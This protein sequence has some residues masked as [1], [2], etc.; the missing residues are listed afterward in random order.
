MT[1]FQEGSSAGSRRSFAV[2]KG[3][4]TPCCFR[5]R[6]YFPHGSRDSSADWIRHNARLLSK[7]SG[8]KPT[9]FTEFLFDGVGGNAVPL[10]REVPVVREV[11]RLDG[12]RR[13]GGQ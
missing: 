6:R 11:Q 7:C 3:G 2:L 4:I 13:Q 5:P 10:G 9:Q 12:M 1:I 8:T